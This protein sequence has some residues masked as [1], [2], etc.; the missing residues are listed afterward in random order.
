MSP[1]DEMLQSDT[2]MRTRQSLEDERQKLNEILKDY[3][4]PM[5]V[6]TGDL[7]DSVGLS[8]EDTIHRKHGIR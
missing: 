4:T 3:R 6:D 2:A 7:G 5:P 8:M 1:D